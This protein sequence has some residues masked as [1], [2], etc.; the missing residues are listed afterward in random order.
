MRMVLKASGISKE[1]TQANPDA[2]L[3]VLKFHMDG[4]KPKVP[5]RQS[6]AVRM[7][8]AV[9]LKEVD[10]KKCFRNM[11][12]LGQGASGIVYAATSIAT[13]QKVAL[14]VAPLSELADLINE[15]G[16]Q[17]MSQHPNVVKCLEAYQG[18]EDI[19]IVMELV[20]G[21]CLTDIVAVD[22]PT[23][24]NCIAY[25]CKHMLMALAFMHRQ[26]R[27]HRDIKS[28]NVL[29]SFDVNINM[30]IVYIYIY[31]YIIYECMYILNINLL[32]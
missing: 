3:D 12:K 9:E 28:D 7:N 6:L 21:G 2:V 26:H 8:K 23:P 16:L 22:A 20:D 25:V 5:N 30:Y 11:K 27:L 24:E 13:G 31:I 19:C 10:Y 29:V 18:K 15:I 32:L 4:G 14:K 1:E 17:S